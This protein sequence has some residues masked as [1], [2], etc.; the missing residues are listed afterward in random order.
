MAWESGASPVVVLNKAD[1]CEGLSAEYRAVEEVAIAVPIIPL[2][3]LGQDNLDALTP[4]C[5]PV[6]QCHVLNMRVSQKHD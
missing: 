6:R 5:S 1:L 4:I 2:S 3:A